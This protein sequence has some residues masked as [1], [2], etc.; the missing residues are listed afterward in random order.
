MVRPFKIGKH[1]V[2]RFKG[3][4]HSSEFALLHV[5]PSLCGYLHNFIL[6]LLFWTALTLV[7]TKTFLKHSSKI[8]FCVPQNKK[9]RL[10]IS[11]S[12]LG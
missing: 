1:A 10:F 8:I 3:T 9:K 2:F 5:V 12:T 4:V 11:K 7:F 6:P